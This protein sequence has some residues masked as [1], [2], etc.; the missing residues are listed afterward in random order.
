MKL[1]DKIITD[2][3]K[4]LEDSKINKGFTELSKTKNNLFK[5][6]PG[7]E[8]LISGPQSAFNNIK[9]LIGAYLNQFTNSAEIIQ[10]NVDQFYKKIIISVKP[11]EDLL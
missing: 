5:S 9:G 10:S 1:M 2:N 11:P 3:I 6:I 8:G 4:I 7:L